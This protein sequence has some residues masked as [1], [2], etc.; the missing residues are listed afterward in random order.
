MSASFHNY[1]PIFHHNLPIAV[2][3]R[4][5]LHEPAFKFCRGPGLAGDDDESRAQ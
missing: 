5:L 2:V 1:Q 4:S 3:S